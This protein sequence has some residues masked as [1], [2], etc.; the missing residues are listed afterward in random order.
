MFN[1]VRI[2]TIYY[3]VIVLHTVW[4][5]PFPSVVGISVGAPYSNIEV[6]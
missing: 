6:I 3:M 4:M 1:L 2:K 5:A